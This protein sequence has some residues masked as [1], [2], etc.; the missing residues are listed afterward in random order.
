MM[1]RNGTELGN[2]RPTG[3]WTAHPKGKLRRTSHGDTS[4]TD[5][6][7]CMQGLQLVLE[8]CNSCCSSVGHLSSKILPHIQLLLSSGFLGLLSTTCF[9]PFRFPLKSSTHLFELNPLYFLLFLIITPVHTQGWNC[10][11]V[12]N[13]I[14]H[15]TWPEWAMRSLSSLPQLSPL[16]SHIIESGQGLG[17]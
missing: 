8:M 3:W 9:I 1:F 16:I 17:L 2:S 12:G 10:R 14:Q 5:P 6:Y 13:L 4:S 15:A 11:S 7:F